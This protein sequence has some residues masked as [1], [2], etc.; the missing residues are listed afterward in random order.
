MKFIY[1]FFIFYCFIT[2]LLSPIVLADDLSPVEDD[3]N[4]NEFMHDSNLQTNSAND[5]PTINS[6]AYIILDRK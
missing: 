4:V 1:K 5:F 2:I 6:R 3:F